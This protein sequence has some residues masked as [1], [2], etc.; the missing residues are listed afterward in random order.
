MLRDDINVARPSKKDG[1]KNV[2]ACTMCVS[3]PEN[4]STFSEWICIVL[5]YI[6]DVDQT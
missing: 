6:E 2:H 4:P 5:G 3:S 1:V